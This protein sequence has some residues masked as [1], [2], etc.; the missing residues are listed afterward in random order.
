MHSGDNEPIASLGNCLNVAMI[1]SVI[2]QCLSQLAYRHPEAAVKID[3]RIFTPQ[4]ISKFLPA[5]HLS[6]ILQEGDEKPIGLLLQTHAHAILQ[7]FAR[8][9][10]HLKGAELINNSGMCLHKCPLKVTN[11]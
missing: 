10:V 6:G 1:L 9:D 5:D 7:Q 3:K 2:V 4:T 8:G 11:D